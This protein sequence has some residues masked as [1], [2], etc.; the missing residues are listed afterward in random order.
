VVNGLNRTFTGA[1]QPYQLEALRKLGVN[2]RVDI[3]IKDPGGYQLRVAVR[4]V[5]SERIGSASQFVEIPDL[6]RGR[7][8]L[9][10][11][12]LNAGGLGE[13]GPAMRRFRPGDRESYQ[14]EV[15]NAHRGTAGQAPDLEGKIQVFRDGRLVSTLGFGAIYE[16]PW[17]AKR[18]VMSGEF[19]LGPEMLP[20]DYVLQVIVADK[21]APPQHS[22]ASR[23]ID[24][25]IGPA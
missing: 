15:Y 13:K 10:G 5:A 18:L 3:P 12:V 6:R 25:E 22:T 8:T 24:F 17:N 20:G 19:A 4:D 9:S 11:I 21:L 1:F 14:L 7:L 23:W 2:Y 16:I